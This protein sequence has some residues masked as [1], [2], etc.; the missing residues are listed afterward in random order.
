MRPTAPMGNEY[1]KKGR[2]WTEALKRALARASALE[3]VEPDYR[4]GLDI[5]ASR[6]VRAAME[7]DIDAAERITE[8]IA[9][10]MEGKAATQLPT[11]EDGREVIPITARIELVAAQQHVLPI[12]IKTIDQTGQEQT[13]LLTQVT[14]PKGNSDLP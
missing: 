10:R 1:S 7:G 6:M 8:R 9:D 13:L 5:L 12:D 11:T 14:D 2:Q 3:G 4:R